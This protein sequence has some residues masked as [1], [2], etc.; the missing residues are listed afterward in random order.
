MSKR[1]KPLQQRPV[2]YPFAVGVRMDELTRRALEE[3]ARA[4]KLRPTE[5]ARNLVTRGL[6][7]IDVDAPIR[8]RA[9][10]VRDEAA[11][12]KALHLL[13]EIGGNLHRTYKTLSAG[14]RADSE[15]L[16]LKVELRAI[17]DSLRDALRRGPPA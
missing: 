5:L 16:T 7:T 1:P 11:V 15:L 3:S 2:K 6:D 8:R 13:G 12:R 4:R 9:S 17:A 14:G 10:P